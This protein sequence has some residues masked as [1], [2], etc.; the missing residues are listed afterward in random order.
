M[1]LA[2][3]KKKL[4]LIYIDTVEDTKLTYVNLFVLDFFDKIVNVVVSLT[5]EKYEK[6][7]D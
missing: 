3:L 7:E 4:L 1:E 6:Y 2:Q 5:K